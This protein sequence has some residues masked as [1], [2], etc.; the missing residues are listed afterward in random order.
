MYKNDE[1]WVLYCDY[2]CE[3]WELKQSK[4][5]V[6]ETKEMLPNFSLEIEVRSYKFLTNDDM[7]SLE[8]MCK[9]IKGRTS[10]Q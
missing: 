7:N 6:V 8:G 10:K 5:N 2:C 4:G 3:C 1:C 9:R